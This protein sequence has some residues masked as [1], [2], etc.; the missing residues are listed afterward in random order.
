MSGSWSRDALAR[1]LLALGVESGSSLVVHSSFR[2]L[3]RVEGGVETVVDSLLDAVGSEGVLVVPTF[4]YTSVKFDGS[5]PA[6]TGAIA[7]AVRQ[8][9]AS[10]RSLHPTHSVAAIGAG[11]A[12]LCRNH[13]RLAATDID[14]PLQRV[15]GTGGRVLLLGVG[16]VA[17]TTIH[18]GEFLAGAPYLG[19]PFS[20][21]WPRRHVVV[22]GDG[23]RAVEYDRFP[24]CS[25]A[26]GIV[27][28]GLRARRAIRDGA[29][30][31][32]FAQLI[33]GQAI[34]EET[35]ALLT[36]TPAA[37]LCTDSACYR[38][39]HARLLLSSD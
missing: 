22:D 19:I 38:C 34:I 10:V 36:S 37:L 15:A 9:S 21:T 6:K 35:T 17:N 12:E 16:H 32:T 29:I 13:E 24:G 28:R 31:S 1:Q 23:E 11:A 20:P 18:V 14:T 30:G 3:G 7:E 27:E 39:G 8:R 4:T 5:E 25:R 26:F 33:D 2:A